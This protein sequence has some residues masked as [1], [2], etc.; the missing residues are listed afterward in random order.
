MN[1]I[2]WIILLVLLIPIIGLLIFVIWRHHWS[3]CH[4]EA[5]GW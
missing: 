3:G 2:A 1:T 5:S 4:R